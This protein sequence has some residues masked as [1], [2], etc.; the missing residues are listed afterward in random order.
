MQSSRTMLLL[1]LCV[2]TLPDLAC[3]R[4]AGPVPGPV[5]APGNTQAM[6]TSGHPYTL[7]WSDEF[8]GTG[9][10]D[11]AKWS[12]DTGGNGWGNNE[13]EYYTQRLQNA[14]VENGNLVI[15]TRKEDYQ[16]SHY[17]SARLLTR[18]KASWTYGKMEIRAKLPAGRG[19]WPAIWLLSDTQPLR[20][21]D[22]GEID[23]ME[24]VGF[25]PNQIHATIHCGAYNGVKGNQKTSILSIPSAQDSFHV[26]SVEWT[27]DSMTFSVDQRA[28]LTYNNDHSGYSTWPFQHNFFLIL[29]IAIG[30]NWGGQQGVD[31][32]IFPQQMLVDYVRVYQRQ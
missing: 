32:S 17:T 2:A 20:W 25:D 3:S 28:Y 27:P 24:E 10:P 13:L 4:A 30:G 22:D 14:R 31:D 5:S 15:E 23:I 19:T 18:G 16:G 26:Y 12:Y 7:V 9:L 8:N 11:P 21:P 6:D 29:N 1:F